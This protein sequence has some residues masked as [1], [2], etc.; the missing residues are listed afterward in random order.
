MVGSPTRCR[1]ANASR[2]R[3]QPSGARPLAGRS[4][5][6]PPQQSDRDASGT[7]DAL[8]NARASS[9]QDA[10]ITSGLRFSPTC[11]F[12]SA[13]R[14]EAAA[15]WLNEKT[16]GCCGI[17]SRRHR[18]VGQPSKQAQCH[19]SPAESTAKRNSNLRDASEPICP[20]ALPLL[21]E[22]TRIRTPLRSN[23]LKQRHDELG[24]RQRIG[25][26][27]FGVTME[28]VFTWPILCVAGGVVL[29]AATFA[30][31]NGNGGLAIALFVVA[32][33]EA[34]FG[35]AMVIFTQRRTS[36]S[37]RALPNALRRSVESAD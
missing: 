24:F 9:N 22:T 28:R 27:E 3:G 26:C 8:G 21:F 14:T 33:C 4:L 32:V 31:I 34:V 35:S 5:L 1:S 16:T 6:C 30:L 10:S 19:R 25:R 37:Y 17:V 15:A 12:T 13:I 23:E 36:R 7:S 11:S 18:C 2:G 20:I 29:V